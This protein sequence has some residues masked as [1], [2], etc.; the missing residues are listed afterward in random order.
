[1]GTSHDTLIVNLPGNPAG[2]AQVL[3]LLLPLLLHAVKD[4]RSD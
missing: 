1:V 2:A 3:E 4:L